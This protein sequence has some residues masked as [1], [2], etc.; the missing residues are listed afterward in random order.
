MTVDDFVNIAKNEIKTGYII[1]ALTDEYIVD[2]W[3]LEN[4]DNVLKDKNGKI[5]EVR[6]FNDV[7]ECKISRYDISE[8][9]NYRRI[10]DIEEKCD[11]YDEWQFLDID[12]SISKDED[13]RVTSTGGGKY[14]LPLDSKENARILIR[15]YLGRYELT[16]QARVEDWRVVEF[17]EGE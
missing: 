11:R 9:F 4:A 14:K 6:V 2:R 12:D 10:C 5:L 8:V 17:K 15:Y 13:G 1:A 3:S 7:K 16:G